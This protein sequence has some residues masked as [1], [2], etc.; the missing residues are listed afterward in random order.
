MDCWFYIME[1][2]GRD[3]IWDVENNKILSIEDG[4]SQLMEG[5]V[6]PI[7]KYGLTEDEIK[8]VEGLFKQINDMEEE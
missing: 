8:A 2:V 3:I 7:T 5:M 6:V 4:V 1:E